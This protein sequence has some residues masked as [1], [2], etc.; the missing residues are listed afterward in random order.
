MLFGKNG[1]P[2]AEKLAAAAAEVYGDANKN[3]NKNKDAKPEEESVKDSSV[4]NFGGIGSLAKTEDVE[5]P[6][7]E[8]R[9]ESE[10]AEFGTYERY[11]ADELLTKYENSKAYREGSSSRKIAVRVD[12]LIEIEDELENEDEK[13]KFAEEIAALKE[14]GVVD[15]SCEK[16][17]ETAI[18]RIWLVIDDNAIKNA[19]KVAGR[20][21]KIDI[22]NDFL[23]DIDK[24]V[25]SMLPGSNYAEFLKAEK[26]RVAEKKD[27]T[28][29]FFED[30]VKN[31]GLLRF[32]LFLDANEEN[33]T[34]QMERVL[35]KRLFADSKY[36][37]REL[38]GKAISILQ[39]IKKE[40]EEGGA[41]NGSTSVSAEEGDRLLAEKGIVRY[42]EIFEFA[43]EVSV[44]FDDG[45]SADFSTLTYGACISALMAARVMSVTF[46]NV[47]R[48]LFI[49][50]KAVYMH[51]LMNQK[52]AGDLVLFH[53]GFV[54]PAKAGWFKCITGE[55]ERNDIPAF[56]WG[57]IDFAGFRKF[58]TIKKEFCPRLKSYEMDSGTLRLYAKYTDPLEDESERKQ[59]EALYRDKD[60]DT[61]YPVIRYMLEN[62]V[63]LEQES[64]PVD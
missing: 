38:R 9:T 33:K 2:S 58:V 20:R 34:E 35:S 10:N 23:R 47:N 14:R 37:E 56:F 42:P 50:N 27:F 61:F 22:V 5:S 59:L 60:Y 15:Y 52:K 45:H 7:T 17:D 16:D 36:F 25:Q 4:S 43:G 32:L 12:Q 11:I 1:K 57:D 62:R 55:A 6:K 53:G 13:K 24:T 51:Y 39:T 18:D 3:A 21:P 41:Q 46:R 28:R 48:L 30:S 44:M 29:Y 54:S 49:E 31:A 63:T 40:Y 19:Y 26:K 8:N 64:I